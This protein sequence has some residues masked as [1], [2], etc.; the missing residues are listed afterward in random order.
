MSEAIF[1]NI[2]EALTALLGKVEELLGSISEAIQTTR[3]IQVGSVLANVCIHLEERYVGKVR[4]R[5]FDDLSAVFGQTT[6]HCR[7]RN[8][9]TKFED[10]D[11]SKDLWLGRTRRLER[12]RSRGSFSFESFYFPRWLL[13]ENLSVIGF[14]E[15]LPFQASYPGLSDL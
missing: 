5:D 15:I 7:A 11:T 6:T 2:D 9:A 1:G 4:R 14:L 3:P 13:K 8:D 10:A 12:K